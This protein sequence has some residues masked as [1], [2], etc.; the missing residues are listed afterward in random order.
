MMPLRIR[1]RKSA[2]GS[3]IDMRSPA[4]LRIAGDVAL[5]SEL[6]QAD[7]A[8]AELAVHRARTAA[9]A[10][11]RMGPRLVL[12]RAACANDLGCLSHGSG[13]SL[14]SYWLFS[15][16]L[17]VARTAVTGEG[18]AERVEQRERLGV[19]RGRRR[20]RDVEATHLV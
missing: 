15:E 16:G 14:S 2:I 19:R 10:A 6:A 1:V 11:A 12:R 9:A 4:R 17:V 20:D 3:V 5:V 13:S 18:H 8:E 7:A